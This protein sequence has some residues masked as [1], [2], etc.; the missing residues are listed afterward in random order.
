MTDQEEPEIERDL[1]RRNTSRRRALEVIL[2]AAAVALGGNCLRAAGAS[3]Q[4]RLVRTNPRVKIGTVAD[5][6][7]GTAKMAE[8]YGQPV[9]VFSH[10]GTIT[11]FS[12]ICTHEGCIVDWNANQ[13]I[14]EC[15]CHDGQYD[16]EG[17]VIAGP[18]PAPLLRFRVVIEDGSV[19]LDG[20]AEEK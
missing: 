2:G 20:I 1:L 3:A 9:L 11:A 4:S 7:A 10:Q 17:K 8:Y 5:F 18:P 13:Q 14:I 6:P 16:T 15:P 19:Y 12:A